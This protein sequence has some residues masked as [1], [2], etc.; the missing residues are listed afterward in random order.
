MIC[1]GSFLLSRNFHMDK[2]KH[3]SSVNKTDL[4]NIPVLL[5]SD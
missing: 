4:Q 5:K 2:I 3:T 1:R